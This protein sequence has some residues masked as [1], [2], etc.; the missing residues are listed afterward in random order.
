LPLLGE[1]RVFLYDEDMIKEPFL[2]YVPPH[3]A[4]IWGI[5]FGV[6]HP[7]AASLLLWDRDNDVIHVHQAFAMKGDENT[8]WLTQPMFHASQMKK[9]SASVPVAWPHDGHQRRQ[10]AGANSTA[11][12]AAIYKQQG[13]LML[14][15]HATWPEGGYGVEPAI[16][17]IEDRIMTGRFKVSAHLGEWFEEYRFYHRDNGLIVA[18]RDDTLSATWKGLMMKRFSKAVPL[19]TWVRNR[20]DRQARATL[21]QN[22]GDEYFGIDS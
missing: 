3:W 14:P 11:S 18:E 21:D 20:Q 4:K 22:A 16:K 9:Y 10:G 2:D 1:G 7:F 6:N 13:L 12:I 8:P 17:E 15:S 19:G 5:D